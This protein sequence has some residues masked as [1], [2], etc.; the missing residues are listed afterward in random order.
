MVDYRFRNATNIRRTLGGGQDQE[1]LMPGE[2]KIYDPDKLIANDIDELTEGF[3]TVAPDLP[4]SYYDAGGESTNVAKMKAQIKKFVAQIAYEKDLENAV[5]STPKELKIQS[6]SGNGAVIEYDDSEVDVAVI[7]GDVSIEES[8]P[9]KM[10]NGEAI[11]N[12][13]CNTVGE[14]VL[15]LENGPANINVSSEIQIEAE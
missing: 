2:T 6:L 4:Q 10:V 3:I 13:T 14:H 5:V 7:S 15:G 1:T 9:I 11:I 8:N 12:V